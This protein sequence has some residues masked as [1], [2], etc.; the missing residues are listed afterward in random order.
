M[1]DLEVSSFVPVHLLEES[2]VRWNVEGFSGERLEESRDAVRV[3]LQNDVY[4]SG[5][6]GIT[7]DHG[8]HPTGDH[9]A[10]AQPFERL[11]EQPYEVRVAHR[12]P[13]RARS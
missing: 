10:D 13:P 11:D 6:S 7:V 5:E 9:V 1:D 4:I 12:P 2:L 3:K 8:G